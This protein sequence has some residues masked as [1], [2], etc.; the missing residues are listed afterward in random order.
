MDAKDKT[1][2]LEKLREEFDPKLIGKLPKPSKTQTD[3]VKKD[4]RKGIRCAICGGWH[5]PDVVHLDYVGHAAATDRL[6]DADL[7]WSWEPMAL[8]DNSLP[9]FGADG[10]LWIKLTVC[11]V[12]RLGYGS[13]DGKKGGNAIKEAIGD[14]I[15]NAG[16]R[17]GIALD[18]WCK[19]DLHGENN[20]D[21][22]N[23]KGNEQNGDSTPPEQPPKLT[24]ADFIEKVDVFETAAA[25]TEWRDAHL[26]KAKVL[27]DTDFKWFENYIEQLIKSFQKPQ[28]IKC[29]Q[30]DKDAP[31]ADCKLADCHNT[32]DVYQAAIK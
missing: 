27:S 3:T 15:R 21:G 20:D 28:F 5:H 1:K 29:P 7:D 16:M 31:V 4:F 11:G 26:Q 22:D 19:E 6:L 25:L 9:K 10:G 2:G 23:G 24:K 17:F 18:L 14:A 13:A 32:C 12:T 8:D 30:S